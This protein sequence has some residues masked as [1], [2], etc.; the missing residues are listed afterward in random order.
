MSSVYRRPAF[1]LLAALALA[2]CVLA[3]APGL[4]GPFVFDS[5]ERVIHN[6][7]LMMTSL[8]PAELLR[9]AYAAQARYPQR[10]LA[11]VSFALNYF[12]AG[13]R[14]DPLAF[15]LTNLLIH[16]TNALLVFFL[17]R[18]V[19]ARWVS[20]ETPAASSAETRVAFAAL[21]AAALWMLH[22]IQ[23]TSVLYVVQRMT[24]LAALWVF[25]GAI[26]FLEGRERLER[27]APGAMALMVGGIVTGVL[28]GFLCKQN[29]LL[30]PLLCG[31][32]ELCLFDTRRLPSRAKARLAW[33]YGLVLAVP[34]L[35]A[36]L[37]LVVRPD[38]VLDAY[39][40][41][42]FGPVERLLTEARVL[43]Y[44]LRWL[45]VP[46][47]RE[48]GLYHDDIPA[49]AGILVPWTTLASLAAWAVLIPLALVGARRRAPWSLALLWFLVGHGLE[50][51]VIGLE[52]IH[53][54]RNYVPSA[55]L[56]MAAAYYGSRLA[57]GRREL[58]RPALAVGIAVG[59]VLAFVT[60]MRAASWRTPAALMERLAR[61]HPDSYRSLSGYAFNVVPANAD[62]GVRFA[63]FQRAASLNHQ[64]V[65]ALIEMSKT[66]N[67]LR[68]A[69][70][71]AAPERAAL[72]EPAASLAGG[73][74]EVEGLRLE[75]DPAAT[76]TLLG[77]LDLEIRRRLARQPVRTD[78]VV[79][80]VG[81]VDC[82]LSGT[83]YCFGLGNAIRE[84]HLAALGNDRLQR[85]DRAVLELSLA[86]VFVADGD[87]DQA[88]TRAQRAGE[89]APENISYRVQAANLYAALGRWDEL[90]IALA[91]LRRDVGE[92]AT[93][94][95][96]IQELERRYR[97]HLGK[98]GG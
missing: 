88:V 5:V 64:A 43:L 82:M 79:A 77:A 60:G 29:A 94:Y 83:S 75:A 69:L 42:E 90:A 44:Y 66:G 27:G 7:A 78:S 39:R 91:D 34:A 23:L 15:K 55:G 46:D 3:Y 86:K 20:T 19:V 72:P 21:F 17:A 31:V 68:H 26:A 65:S 85:M 6:E 67:A 58:R 10:G 13:G 18:S 81:V 47:L 16:L 41:R 80:L 73:P 95:R 22:P 52:L 53:E 2:G 97:E 62:L 87:F 96:G 36:V 98:Q 89:I 57:A 54:H 9:A 14:F 24:S 25:I 37:A 61:H 48:L 76:E 28:L 84:W 70:M 51:G 92:G 49:S 12:L 4:P 74:L 93:A 33:L 30:L 8:D 32:L 1:A 40:Y 38:L 56:A 50:S 71:G 45:L 59:L 63:A 11:Y 35:V